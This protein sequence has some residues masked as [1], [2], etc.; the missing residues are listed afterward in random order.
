MNSKKIMAIV[1]AVAMLCT[2]GFMYSIVYKQSE[3]N[4]QKMLE[5]ESEIGKL[6]EVSTKAKEMDDKIKESCD[7]EKENSD[8]TFMESNSVYYST[9]GD[10][11][12]YFP[13]EVFKYIEV[14]EDDNNTE[15]KGSI[16]FAYT[17]KNDGTQQDAFI[18][19]YGGPELKEDLDVRDSLFMVYD[20]KYYVATLPSDLAIGDDPEDIRKFRKFQGLC[21]ELTERFIAPC[22][23]SEK[24][25]TKE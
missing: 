5:L 22:K 18:I 23:S 3:S 7:Q 8:R 19:T 6:Q 13:S 12:F 1:V 14:Y 20:G 9:K 10:F 21:G 16:A 17:I 25:S 11:G 24:I 2:L 4:K 15:K